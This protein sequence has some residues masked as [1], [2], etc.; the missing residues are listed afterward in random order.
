MAGSRLLIHSSIYDE[1]IE[2]VT[3]H[4]K[5]TV[6]LGNALD[7]STSM[8]PIAFDRQYEKVKSYIELG[9]KEGAELAFGGR[10]RQLQP[11]LGEELAV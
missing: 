6:R 5:E 4:V 1:L 2:K 10:G 11:A 8:G 9:Q 3:A 7:H